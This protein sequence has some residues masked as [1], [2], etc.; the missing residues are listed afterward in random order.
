MLV[1][2]NCDVNLNN[3]I[4]IYFKVVAL[5]SGLYIILSIFA[6]ATIVAAKWA[7]FGRRKPG[8][9]DWDKSS[10]CQRW[11]VLNVSCDL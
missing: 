7:L 3:P 8:T 5:L 1:R 4:K 9:Y 10:Y 2:I 11:Q 6:L